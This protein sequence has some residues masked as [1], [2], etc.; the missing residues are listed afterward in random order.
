MQSSQHN[1]PTRQ[2][3][4]QATLSS[5]H[6]NLKRFRPT[7]PLV[8]QNHQK[9][10]STTITLY[11]ERFPLAELRDISLE[12]LLQQRHRQFVII[13]Y[14]LR[15]LVTPGNAK[16]IKVSHSPRLEIYGR[17]IISSGDYQKCATSNRIKWPGFDLGNCL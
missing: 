7:L 6:S 12:S 2:L 3:D 11:S 16:P 15:I 9:T 17:D 8:L 5:T 1:N 14:V 10:P 4:C 13:L